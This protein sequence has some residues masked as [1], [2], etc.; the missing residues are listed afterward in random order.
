[1]SYDLSNLPKITMYKNIIELAAIAAKD[2]P[3]AIMKKLRKHDPGF[4]QDCDLEIESYLSR[5]S[6]LSFGDFAVLLEDCYA[7]YAIEEEFIN[8][9]T[10][11]PAQRHVMYEEVKLSV[12]ELRR[13]KLRPYAVI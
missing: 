12:P 5:K 13:C 2:T 8:R 4:V 7:R 11:D 3:S 9:F 6:S 1:M 10:D